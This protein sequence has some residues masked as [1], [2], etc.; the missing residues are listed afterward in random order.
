MKSLLYNRPA[1][2]SFRQPFYC[3]GLIFQRADDVTNGLP[4]FCREMLYA[5]V[6]HA[7]PKIG[8]LD[9]DI[10]GFYADGSADSIS[11]F[12]VQSGSAAH[13]VFEACG[14]N[15]REFN[16]ITVSEPMEVNF[17]LQCIDS[18]VRFALQ[19]GLTSVS[20]VYILH[21]YCRY[22]RQKCNSYTEY[23]LLI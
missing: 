8:S 4:Q 9:D 13:Q 10:T 14:R 23:N 5:D 17:F 19:S 7:F 15:T 22:R 1:F 16:D 20:L 18:R 12:N 2:C 21:F 3:S 11:V 6:V